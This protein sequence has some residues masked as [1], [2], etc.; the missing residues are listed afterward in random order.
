MTIPICIA[1]VC[2]RV[3]VHPHSVHGRKLLAG[4]S[5]Q[6]ASSV[7]V[8]RLLSSQ[9]HSSSC[10]GHMARSSTL[11]GS[12]RHLRRQKF[13]TRHLLTQCSS[14]DG[15]HITT[16]RIGMAL[17]AA[18]TAFANPERDDAVAELG[19]LTG[20]TALK[21]IL[22]RMSADEMGARIVRERWDISEESLQVRAGPV[23]CQFGRLCH[24]LPAQALC[25]VVCPATFPRY[26]AVCWSRSTLF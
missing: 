1:R 15:R 10:Q 3:G 17:N 9:Q 5:I 22:Q 8:P 2:A 14:I 21:A 13:R 19:E 12:W 11:F 7:R 23:F 16:D 18:L 25:Y 26:S 6:R 4:C 20:E 24:I